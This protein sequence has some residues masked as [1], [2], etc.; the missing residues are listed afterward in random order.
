[1]TP[2]LSIL[3]PVSDKGNEGPYLLLSCEENTTTTFSLF[4]PPSAHFPFPS[5]ASSP[6]SFLSAYF[7]FLRLS[8]PP[9]LCL[10]RP[11]PSP[12][13]IG[14]P[15]PRS[16]ASPFPLLPFSLFHRLYASSNRYGIKA[17]NR[18][19]V[20]ESMG[21][22]QGF[23]NDPLRTLIYTR[24]RISPNR[25]GLETFKRFRLLTSSDLSV[26]LSVYLSLSRS[27]LVTRS[28]VRSKKQYTGL[29]REG[30]HKVW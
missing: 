25:H 5:S 4:S 13:L 1:M 14:S 28:H 9:S 29:S 27:L 11:S 23:G 21:I 30:L 24:Q 7:L 20:Y 15:P 16:L 26:C 10:L 6:H 3:V 12:S 19:G 2:G 8:F 22:R 18:A 17:R